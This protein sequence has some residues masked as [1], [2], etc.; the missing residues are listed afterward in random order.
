MSAQ[1]ILKFAPVATAIA[2]CAGCVTTAPK[3][4]TTNTLAAPA[5]QG[6]AYAASY[7]KVWGAVLAVLQEE[8]MTLNVVDKASGIA[9]G[10]KN[11]TP[12]TADM[13]MGYSVRTLVSAT[14]S[15]GDPGGV[16]V[17][18]RGTMERKYKKAEW[19]PD[20]VTDTSEYVNS[21]YGKIA[22]RVR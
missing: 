11:V 5:V 1:L 6:R 20:T 16:K 12:S 14:A 19:R 13:M 8:E 21:L 10:V 22:A 4:T 9:S 2:L 7:D 17:T 15:Q 3:V 18:L